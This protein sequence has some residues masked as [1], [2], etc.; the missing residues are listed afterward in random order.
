MSFTGMFNLLRAGL[1]R[2]V[3][4]LLMLAWSVGAWALSPYFYGN[5]VARGDTRSV[6]HAVE[7]KLAKSGFTVAGSYIPNG[8]S[9]YG[10][11]VATDPDLTR[12]ISQLGGDAI[13]G[14]GI[15]VGV[16]NDGTVSYINPEYWQRAYLR[17]H[18]NGGAGGVVN[19]IMGRLQ[20]ALGA[21]KP[22]GGDVD[23]RDL[24]D[25]QYMF[26]MEGFE[27]EKNLVGEGLSF[28]DMVKAVRDN[29]VRGAANTGKVYEVVLPEKKVAVFGVAMNDPKEGE[30]W[31]VKTVHE[32]HIAALPYELYIINN[33][34]YHLF[35]RYRIALS[36]PDTGMGTF[37]RI[38][39]APDVI[40]E[41]MIAV[42]GSPKK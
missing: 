5:K 20:R 1:G 18:F 15:R 31:W 27:S 34:A 11:I 38:V 40:R 13:V 30:A 26:G 7:G 22:F 9:N 35:A 12:L 28:D 8:M 16:R 32:E 10:V 42:A 36:W 29:L 6:M 21:G 4:A 37:M 2:S 24:P 33:K 23:K 19:A 3:L 41:T 17:K 25:Y 14:A 39:E